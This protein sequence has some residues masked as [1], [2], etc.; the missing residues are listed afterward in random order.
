MPTDLAVVEL[1]DLFV[2]KL[3]ILKS[4]STTVFRSGDGFEPAATF[5]APVALPLNHRA[6]DE[7]SKH[8]CGGHDRINGR[9]RKSDPQHEP[10]DRAQ[11][12]ADNSREKENILLELRALAI[13]LRTSSPPV[14]AFSSWT[15]HRRFSTGR[16]NACQLRCATRK[17]CPDPS[18][19]SYATHQCRV[20]ASRVDRSKMNLRGHGHTVH[21]RTPRVNH[22][23]HMTWKSTSAAST[24]SSV[25]ATP[26]KRSV[27]S[28]ISV[29]PHQALRATTVR[30]AAAST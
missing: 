23:S 21:L 4:D 14:A 9:G 17:S 19:D 1:G 24:S 25:M 12:A 28:R 8:S 3:A 26:C 18:L 30:S 6:R 7:R 2:A 11:K 22:G 5:R 10:D 15:T 27:S 29:R 13:S 20:A 16:N